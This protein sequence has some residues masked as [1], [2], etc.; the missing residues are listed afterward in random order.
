MDTGKDAPC[1]FIG[2]AELP[3]KLLYGNAGFGMRHKEHRVEPQAQWCCSFFKNSTGKRI[4]L[5]PTG[6]TSIC[7]SPAYFVMFCHCLA[8]N[9]TDSSRITKLLHFFKA[10]VIIGK[11]HKKL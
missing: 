8:C 5:I 10:C 2:H 4:D 7:S 11:P 3:L 9:T 6:F 1:S